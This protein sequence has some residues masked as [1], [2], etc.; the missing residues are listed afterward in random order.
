VGEEGRR[1]LPPS[2]CFAPAPAA[3]LEETVAATKTFEFDV[4][5][6]TDAEAMLARARQRA[7]EVGITIEGDVTCGTFRGTAEGRYTVEAASV[8]LDVDKKPAF[9]PWSLVEKGLAKAFG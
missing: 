6:G 2:V 1:S 4:P 9:V 5:E 3:P 8:R 7:R